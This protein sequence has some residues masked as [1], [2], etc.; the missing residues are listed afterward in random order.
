MGTTFGTNIAPLEG[1]FQKEGGLLKG[2]KGFDLLIRTRP[3]GKRT[4]SKTTQYILKV[5]GDGTRKY[6]SS[7]WQTRRAGVHEFEFQGIRY[8]VDLNSPVPFIHPLRDTRE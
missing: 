8:A 4:A 2:K 7:L 6:V 1:Y 5:N 3:A